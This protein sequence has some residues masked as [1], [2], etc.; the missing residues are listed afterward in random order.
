MQGGDRYGDGY[1]VER[2]VARRGCEKPEMTENKANRGPR[3]LI[4]VDH[5]SRRDAANLTLERVTA[6]L[7]AKVGERY[8]AVEAAHMELAS[9]SIADAVRACHAAG[10]RHLVVSLFFLAP[11]RHVTEDIPELVAEAAGEHP[12]L[13]WELTPPLCESEALC[14]ALIDLTPE[15]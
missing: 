4:V 9:P 6:A 12:G 2:R 15:A 1:T 10:A 13:T 7:K 11:G 3:G 8:A 5:G 14:D